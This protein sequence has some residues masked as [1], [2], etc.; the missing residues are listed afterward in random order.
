LKKINIPGID[1]SCSRFIFGTASLF[2]VGTKKERYNLLKSAIDAGF[3]HFDTAPY[4]GFGVA[5][6]DLGLVAREH[7]E[8]TITTKVGIY[9]P[10]GEEQPDV[11]VFARKAAGRLIS[12]LSAPTKSFNLQKATKALESSLRRIGRDHIEIYTLHEPDAGQVKTDEWLRWLEDRVSE[13]KVG[14]FGLAVTADRIAPIAAECPDLCR[15]VQVF[16]SLET[17]E[18]DTL[19]TYDLPMQ[20]TYGYVSAA[21]KHGNQASVPDILKGALQRNTRGA[22]IVSTTKPERTKQYRDILDGIPS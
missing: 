20:V 4:Y 7:P 9:S 21:R 1:L 6:R 8:I 18:A 14:H 10:G 5:E 17:Q 3:S 22:I 11:M 2:N 15:F 13:G 16:D 19:A 12:N